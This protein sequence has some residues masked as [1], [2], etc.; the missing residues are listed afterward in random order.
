MFKAAG[1]DAAELGGVDAPT[2]EPSV[3][4][5]A[6]SALQDAYNDIRAA[7][8]AGI[9]ASKASLHDGRTGATCAH[10]S[11]WTAL[12]VVFECS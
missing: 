8:H 6:G 5:G 10:A 4:E 11:S 2:A 12:L 7:D 1:R 3:S 9:L